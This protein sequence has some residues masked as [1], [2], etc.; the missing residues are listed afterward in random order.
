[1]EVVYKQSV[2]RE[3]QSGG[4]GR[5]IVRS[6]EKRQT[7]KSTNHFVQMRLFTIYVKG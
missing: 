2:L 7:D 3:L 4:G 6:I 1:M 5:V